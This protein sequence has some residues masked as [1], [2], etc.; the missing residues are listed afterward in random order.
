M[1]DNDKSLEIINHLLVETFHEILKVE[2]QSLRLA[3]GAAVTVT[4]LHT[5][6]AIGNGEP[7]TV[8]A[9][10]AAMRVT[11]ST[12]T[13][14]INR[15]EKKGFVERVRES[16]DRR[17][18]R[19]KL[20]DQGKK[21]AYIHRRFH[22]RMARAVVDRLDSQEVTVLCRAIENL[23]EFFRAES[24]HNARRREGQEQAM[25]APGPGGQG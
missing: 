8:S 9:L 11:V 4:E 24:E 7:R 22:R 3:A 20:T 19:V 10:A 15:L 12:M 17:L 1:S 25:A 18:V 14:G 5:L 21:L 6:D 23:K 16:G 2:E 13:I